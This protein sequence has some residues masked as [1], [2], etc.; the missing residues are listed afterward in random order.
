MV[1]IPSENEFGVWQHPLTSNLLDFSL[2]ASLLS[3]PGW[4][5]RSG[6]RCGVG[7]AV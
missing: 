3:S 6:F 7:A 4:C 1:Q 5:C 2:N